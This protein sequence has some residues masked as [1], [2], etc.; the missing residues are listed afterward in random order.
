MIDDADLRTDLDLALA[1]LLAARLNVGC[2]A[3][4]PEPPAEAL[5]AAQA[6]DARH[7]EARKAFRRAWADLTALVPQEAAHAALE[8]EAAVNA[9][10]VSGIRVGWNLGSVAR[11]VGG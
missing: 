2:L 9:L 4:T 7:P 8:A 3:A 10:V 11:R 5:D 6:V 1:H